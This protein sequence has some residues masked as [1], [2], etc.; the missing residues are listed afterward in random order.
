MK[1]IQTEILIHASPERVWDFFMD[2]A[3][4]PNWNP[5]IK[6]LNGIPQAGKKLKA[7]LYPK[8]KSSMVFEPIV[9]RVT[10]QREFR[11]R[12]KLW[13]RGLF[14]GEHYFQLIPVGKDQTKFIHAENF[15]G[16][17]AG[18][19]LGMIGEATKQSFHEM[20]QALKEAVEKREGYK[21]K[22]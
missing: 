8:G 16:L 14:D 1:E 7:T 11:W 9:V 6:E 12:G 5:F 18:A 4:Y 19:I 13:I 2:F 3:N 20:N 17:L 10:P 15:S 22:V 21:E